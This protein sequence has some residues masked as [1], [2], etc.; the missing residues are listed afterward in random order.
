[1]ADD[2]SVSLWWVVV[3]V[4]LALSLGAGAVLYV[5]GDLLA[6]VWFGFSG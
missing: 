4:L 6:S 2:D 5:G 3:F 1:M